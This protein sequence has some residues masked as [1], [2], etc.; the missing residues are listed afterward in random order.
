M[1]TFNVI[2]NNVMSNIQM[3]DTYLTLIYIHRYSKMKLFTKKMSFTFST[4]SYYVN[5]FL[6][7]SLILFLIINL[8]KLFI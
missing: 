2:S 8:E 4:F 6:S 7:I 1:C 5:S 3:L